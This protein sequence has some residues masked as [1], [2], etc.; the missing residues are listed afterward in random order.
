MRRARAELLFAAFLWAFTLFVLGAALV[1]GNTGAPAA[2]WLVVLAWL[3]TAGLPTTAA[4]VGLAAL[5]RG[6]SPAAFLAAAGALGFALQFAG[7][8]IVQR[9]RRKHRRRP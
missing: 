3:V 1:L 4:V 9:L 6:P 5:W 7:V 8:S 2:L